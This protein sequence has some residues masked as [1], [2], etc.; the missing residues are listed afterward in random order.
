[1]KKIILFI[2]LML[3]T[4]YI[5]NS[6][7]SKVNTL[8]KRKILILPFINK[9]NVPEYD[10]LSGIIMETLRS[11]LIE[12]DKYEFTNF[13]LTN[14]K[15]SN[16]YKKEDFIN[17]KKA[18]NIAIQL[19]A[20]IVITGQYL[21]FDNRIMVLIHTIDILTG[22]LV[23]LTKIEGNT[24]VELFAVINNASKDMTKKIIDTL[25]LI[26][27]EIYETK[28]IK[29]NNSIITPI[30]KIGI[31]L[32]ITGSSLLLIGIPILIYDLAGYSQI[33]KANK[34]HYLDT[35]EGYNEYDQSYNIFIG[36]LLSGIT[37]TGIGFIMVAAGLPLLLINKVQNKKKNISFD[38]KID[39]NLAFAVKFQL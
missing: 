21:I 4:L 17:L 13:S 12:T 8:I 18:K 11:E 3:N 26:D 24:G 27:K 15:L 38:I 23:A 39:R 19:N 25:P 31:S 16:E 7:L 20:D 10:Y 37:I 35:R 22:E 30:K 14:T 28:M 34:D 9:N 33:L 5:F 32:I 2:I 29:I 36:L 1:M 6:D